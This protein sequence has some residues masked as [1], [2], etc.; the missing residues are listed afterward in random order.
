ML[1]LP[2]GQ[3]LRWLG[4]A[5]AASTSLRCGRQKEKLHSCE[6]NDTLLSKQIALLRLQYTKPPPL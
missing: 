1:Q 3:R 4:A 2:E 5:R 6:L